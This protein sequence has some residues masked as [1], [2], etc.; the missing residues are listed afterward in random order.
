MFGTILR[1]LCCRRAQCH[2]FW[3]TLTGLPPTVLGELGIK[4]L[5]LFQTG[6]PIAALS[7]T[8]GSLRLD[9]RERDILIEQYLP[10]AIETSQKSSCCLMNVY[11]EKEFDT[12]LEEL[13]DR[14]NVRPAPRAEL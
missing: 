6:L 5:E 12:P 9:A 2:D 3:H 14:L 10:W 13:R 8:V 4:W 1:P 11:Y 7:S